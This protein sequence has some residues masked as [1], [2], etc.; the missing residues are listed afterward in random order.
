MAD[1]ETDRTGKLERTL[2]A[3]KPD[4]INRCLIGEIISRF[5]KRGF[6]LVGMKFAKVTFSDFAFINIFYQYK[7]LLHTA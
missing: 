4:G 6:K 3:I 2:V 5:E 7:E 1:E